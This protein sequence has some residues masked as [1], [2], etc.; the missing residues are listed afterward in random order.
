MS[1]PKV[2]RVVTREEL[3]AICEGNIAALKAALEQWRKV[4]LRNEL[5]TDEDVRIAERRITAMRE[6]LAA[7]RFAEI[8]KQVPL[9]IAFLKTDMTRRIERAVEEKAQ[10]RNEDRRRIRAA[11]ALARALTAKGVAA[12]AALRNPGAQSGEQ[13][14]AAITVA[15]NL[16]APSA[17]GDSPTDRQRELAAKLA[18]DESRPTLAQWLSAQPDTRQAATDTFEV[19]RRLD[20]LRS[21][22]PARAEAFVAR[23]SLISTDTSP[24]RSLLIDSLAADIAQSRWEGIAEA[25]AWEELDAVLEQ[26]ATISKSSPQELLSDAEK[27][28]ASSPTVSDIQK[29]VS[30]TKKD[31]AKHVKIQAEIA[32]RSALLEGLSELGYVVKEGM[33]TAWVENGRVVLTSSKSPNYGVE[34]GGDPNSN[35][36]LRTVRFGDADAAG[37][38][39]ADSAAETAFCGDF[40][41]L[42]GKIA[43]AGGELTIV[44]ALGIGA[45][46]VKR[47]VAD[48]PLAE[49]RNTN[50]NVPAP[51]RKL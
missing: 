4:G 24:R 6:M 12:P 20:E 7:D 36:Q 1:G 47:V 19:E 34:I 27:L 22:N 8:Q 48:S 39:V 3:I 10:A 32:K 51:S 13:L 30:R 28:R 49:V 23:L 5:I 16:L 26:L 43:E 2:V 42:Q 41:K 40:S 15:F 25:N 37:D 45:T 17:A 11:E 38:V 29:L 35:M 18:E 46:P 44:K 31:V 21:L 33:Q 14:Q 9:E 50:V